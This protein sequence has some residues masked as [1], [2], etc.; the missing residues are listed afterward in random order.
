M[1]AKILIKGSSKGK[2]IGKNNFG[3]VGILECN[4]MQIKRRLMGEGNMQNNYFCKRGCNNSVFYLPSL[5]QEEKFLSFQTTNNPLSQMLLFLFSAFLLLFPQINSLKAMENSQVEKLEK[6]TKRESILESSQEFSLKKRKIEK[7]KEDAVQNNAILDLDEVARE[8]AK[9]AKSEGQNAPIALKELERLANEENNPAAQ[10]NLGWMYVIGLGVKKD[11]DQAVELFQKAAIQ[12]YKNAFIKLKQ[13]AEKENHPAAQYSLGCLLKSKNWFLEADKQ[14]YPDA[15]YQLGILYEEKNAFDKAANCFM[16]EAARKHQD[17]LKA[18]QAL[19]DKKNLT[20][21]A[22]LGYLYMG[23]T[24]VPMDLEK[25]KKYLEEPAMKSNADAQY[26]LGKLYRTEGNRKETSKWIK[27][28]AKQE[29]MDAQYELGCIYE[30]QKNLKKAAKLVTKAADS[31]H[32]DAQYKL[33]CMYAEGRGVKKNLLKAADL[34]TE[35]A[36]EGHEQALIKLEN[37]ADQLKEPYIFIKLG[38]IYKE[39]N[40]KVSDGWYKKAKKQETKKTCKKPSDLSESELDLSVLELDS[41]ELESDLSKGYEPSSS[42]SDSGEYSDDECDILNKKAKNNDQLNLEESNAYFALY[43]G[44]HYIKILFTDEN[45]IEENLEHGDDE[46]SEQEAEGIPL[47]SSA[48]Y[49]LAGKKFLSPIASKEVKKYGDIIRTIL[50]AFKRQ[51]EEMYNKFHETYTNNHIQFHNYLENSNQIEDPL[52]KSAFNKYITIFCEE[53]KKAAVPEHWEKAVLRNPFVSFSA[54]PRHAVKYAVGDKSYTGGKAVILTPD[55]QDGIPQNRY[56]GKTYIAVFQPRD[57]KDLEPTFIIDRHAQGDMEIIN[58]YRNDILSEHEIS[59]LGYLPEG[60]IKFSQPMEVPDFSEPTW[61]KDASIIPETSYK[62]WYN[63]SDKERNTEKNIDTLLK[64]V[65][66]KGSAALDLQA[67]KITEEDLEGKLVYFDTISKYVTP[68]ANFGEKKI[69]STAL[70]SVNKEKKNIAFYPS[71]GQSQ[72][73]KEGISSFTTGLTENPPLNTPLNLRFS[74]LNLPDASFR[75]L[76]NNQ[77]NIV[78]LSLFYCNLMK[79]DALNIA[80]HLAENK[81]LK[82]LILDG[83]TVENEGA[84]SFCTALKTN[85]TL[86]RLSLN[87]TGIAK[88]KCFADLFPTGENGY[89]TH[90]NKTLIELN[91]EGNNIQDDEKM[92][93]RRQIGRGLDKNWDHSQNIH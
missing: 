88:V 72:L 60:Y 27:R 7:E 30:E 10:Y 28:S 85:T 18:L 20:A 93:L 81:I 59:F 69:V 37:I 89:N 32:I 53:A 50:K 67:K 92:V 17:A 11:L 61:S 76:M 48:G 90:L 44:H 80:A 66:K 38:D 62:N 68:Q 19:A 35:A 49:T 31:G 91:L 43:R 84:E 41:S 25:A 5:G 86:E 54:T 23:D 36:E 82:S 21:Q 70:H 83:N 79:D 29:N 87:T 8:Q 56:L 52:A 39:K 12:K 34:L 45:K 6:K 77:H 51:S 58:H 65:I 1:D 33:G 40:S 78:S 64:I 2:R 15:A 3:L 74:Y 24:A 57:I 71:S 9:I 55:Y 42:T 13:L 73:T 63:F 47:L 4:V 26:N 46:S 16:R 22:L 75:D 14:D